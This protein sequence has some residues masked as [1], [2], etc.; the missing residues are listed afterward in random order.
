[1]NGLVAPLATPQL[2]LKLTTFV[3]NEMLRAR[4]SKRQHQPVA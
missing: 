1:M 2:M 4:R 3:K